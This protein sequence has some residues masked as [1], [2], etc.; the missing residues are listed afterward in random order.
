[1]QL[2]NLFLIMLAMIIVAVPLPASARES[3]ADQLTQVEISTPEL[4]YAD[5]HSFKASFSIS[6][7]GKASVFGYIYARTAEETKVKCVLMRY[8]GNSWKEYRTWTDDN[9]SSVSSV[10]LDYYV[11]KGYKYK[12]ISYGYA[13]VD[14]ELVDEPIDVSDSIYY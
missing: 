3:P 11:P 13:W 5:V 10:C 6:S 9:S 2:K 4:R 7:T 8:E 1:M 14:G 12:L